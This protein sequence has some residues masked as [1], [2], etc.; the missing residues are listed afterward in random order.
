M[1]LLLQSFLVLLFHGACIGQGAVAGVIKVMPIRRVIPD[2]EVALPS[3]LPKIN[4]FG[5]FNFKKPPGADDAETADA[6][7]QGNSSSSGH[8]A[9]VPG[10]IFRS[11]TNKEWTPRGKLTQGSMCLSGMA[12]ARARAAG[13]FS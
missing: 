13:S 5:R 9:V 12:V 6:T 11:T 10:Y 8:A 3:N 7:Q 4:L 2:R 1:V